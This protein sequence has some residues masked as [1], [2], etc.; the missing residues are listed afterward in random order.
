MKTA[1]TS[2]VEPDMDHATP[3]P[4]R[5]L[6]AVAHAFEGERASLE[7]SR[8]VFLPF[9]RSCRRVLDIG[10]GEGIF[11]DQLERAGI[12]AEGIE[13]DAAMVRSGQERGRRIHQARAESFLRERTASYD[14]VFLGHIVEHLD[15]PDALDLLLDCRRSLLPGGTLVVLTPNFA[16]PEVHQ[17]MFWLDVTH[18]R[19]YPRD[20][21]QQI[22]IALGLEFV[23]EEFLAKGL[24]YYLVGRVPTGDPVPWQDAVWAHRERIATEQLQAAIP[25]EASL[26]LLDEAKLDGPTALSPRRVIPFVELH[27][28]YGGRPDDDAAA[29]RELERL[30]QGGASFAVFAWPAIWWLDHYVEFAHYLRSTYPCVLKNEQ[31]IVFDLRAAA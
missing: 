14:G 8:S 31:V 3:D 2:Q 29:I 6:R 18:R 27:G 30:R 1:H 15:G 19:P 21:L 7:N 24:D 16:H 20:L 10:C 17:R 13:I 12:S 28:S 9:F 11:L 23:A 4:E 5:L 22:F 25:P 26:V